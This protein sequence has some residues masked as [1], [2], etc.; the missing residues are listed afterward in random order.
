[1]AGQRAQQTESQS[2]DDGLL[3]PH[4]S[5]RPSGEIAT[6]QTQFLY[7]TPGPA[8]A[9]AARG[10]RTTIASTNLSNTDLS[11]TDLSNNKERMD[12]PS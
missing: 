12:T 9:S 4:A 11:N 7:G 3:A 10:Q 6:D 8:I 1:M 2:F 5:V